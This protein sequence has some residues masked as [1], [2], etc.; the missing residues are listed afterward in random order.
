M[1]SDDRRLL[2]REPPNRRSD[3]TGCHPR[4]S[5][6]F[7]EPATTGTLGSSVDTASPLSA[8]ASVE[9]SAGVTMPPGGVDDRDE[10]F[11]LEE[12]QDG[13][14]RLAWER[15]LRI[16]GDMARQ[17][18]V[19][20]DKLN[21]G[22]HRPLLVYMAHTNALDREAREH[23]ATECSPSAVALLGE[24]PVDRLLATFILGYGGAPAPTKYFTEESDAIG[25]LLETTPPPA[26]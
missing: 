6:A 13:I 25:W 3:P 1:P 12:G 8:T 18:M 16:T 22:R 2:I 24:T 5:F 20:V 17:A 19:A 15:D 7:R 4:V 9:G 10:P 11:R 26:S 14:V 21:S 23:F